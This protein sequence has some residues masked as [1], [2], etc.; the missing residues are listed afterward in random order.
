MGAER[1]AP[2]RARPTSDGWRAPHTWCDQGP[3]WRE[4][5]KLPRADAQH[6]VHAGRREEGEMRVGTQP[7]IGHEHIT[8]G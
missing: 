3:P 2:A 4:V 5:H 6:G 1:C 8:G 7:P